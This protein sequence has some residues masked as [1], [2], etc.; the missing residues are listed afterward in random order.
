MRKGFRYIVFIAVGISSFV[1]ADTVTNVVTEGFEYS[2]TDEFYAAGWSQREGASGDMVMAD[3]ETSNRLP[4]S[5]D[6]CLLAPSN[7]VPNQIERTFFTDGATDVMVEFYLLHRNMS[8]LNATRSLIKLE[9]DDS[10]SVIQLYFSQSNGS[11]LYRLTENGV[12]GDQTVAPGSLVNSTTVPVV[13]NK[14]GI[15][16]DAS[17][18]ATVYLND[19]EQFTFAQAKNFSTLV[20][21]RGWDEKMGVQSAYDDL[22]VTS[23]ETI[24]PGLTTEGFEYSTTAELYAAG[25]SQREGASNDVVM[26]NSETNN[27]L[28]RSGE[29][30]LLAP[31]DKTPNQLEKTFFES[32][33]VN[34]TVEFYLLHRTMSNLNATRSLIKLES[35]DS[36]SVM[37]LY[38]SQV[39]ASLLYRLTENG[40]EIIHQ[41]VAPGSLVNS[42]TVPVIWNKISIAYNA[43]GSA[44]VYLNDEEQFTFA[45]AENF[46]TLVLGRGWAESE[47][48]QS[49]YDDL[50]ILVESLSY[51]NWAASW[52]DIGSETDDDDGDGLSNLAEYAVGGN[53]AN[54]ADRGEASTFVKD[55][56]GMLFVH[57]QYRRDASLVYYLQTADDLLLNDWT[58]T[59]YTIIG[60]NV[61]DEG[62][63]DFVTNSVPMTRDQ[64]FVRLVVEK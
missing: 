12:E 60:T 29:T 4:R 34:A 43:L 14:I 6:T 54:S 57:P 5:G 40:E 13:W 3:S 27:R 38:F 8:N 16:Y 9:S 37:Q 39:N 2:T 47:S 46:S 11:L 35:D 30:C 59:G 44:T 61:A 20:L 1:N 7:K 19:E 31:G 36:Q 55:G 50:S 42:T 32:G 33:A 51:T 25:W 53:P 49:A 48:A 17:G 15:S 10:Q 22:T 41:A 52:G 62:D 45:G 18:A 26:A 24:V 56:D 21:G 28:P 23:I 64:T 63:F 58:N